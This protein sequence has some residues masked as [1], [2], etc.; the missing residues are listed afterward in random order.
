M[1]ALATATRDLG[2][3]LAA[4]GGTNTFGPGGLAGTPLEQ[5]LPIDMKVPEPD[6]KPP[7]AVMLVLESVESPAGDL[8]VRSAAPQLVANLSPQDLVGVANGLTGIIVPL[9]RVG[10]GKRSKTRSPP[11]RASGTRPVMCPTSRTPPAHWPG[12][13]DDT[14][15]IVVMGDGDADT[16]C[17]RRRSWPASCTRAS[18]S[19]PSAPTFMA[20]PCSWPTWPP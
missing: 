9:Q 1:D 2:V 13:P 16:P 8:V 4:F 7:V 19:L 3:G 6:E 18:R 10:N 11:S 5:A 14:K 20:R 15:Y 17:P 12:H